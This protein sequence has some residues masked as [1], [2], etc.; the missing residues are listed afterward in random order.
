MSKHQKNHISTITF[1]RASAPSLSRI[2]KR[3]ALLLYARLRRA[4]SIHVSIKKR[5]ESQNSYYRHNEIKIYNLYIH[6][7]KL[8][9]F[10]VY[11]CNNDTTVSVILPAAFSSTV[12]RY[13]GACTPDKQQKRACKDF[14]C[15]Q[16]SKTKANSILSYLHEGIIARRRH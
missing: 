12:D 10:S 11:L 6:M 15:K 2:C 16:I 13:G 14:A 4:P 8:H 1:N 3:Q 7:W 5:R 9:F